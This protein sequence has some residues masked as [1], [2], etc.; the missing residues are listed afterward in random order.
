MNL[1]NVH[2]IAKRIQTQLFD[3]ANSYSS[4]MFKS[5]FKGSG[6]QFKEHQVYQYGDEIRFIDWSL[7]AKKN[8][9]Y[10]KTYEE[11]RNIHILIFVDLNPSMGLGSNGVTK[12]KAS[13]EICFLLILLA[14]KTKDYVDIV[15]LD[16]K[17]P[18]YCNN[19]TGESGVA[20]LLSVLYKY[21]VLHSDGKI[22]YEKL[23]KKGPFEIGPREIMKFLTRK[24]EVVFLSDYKN[25]IDKKLLLLLSKNYHAHFFCLRAPI[26]R[27]SVDNKV[28]SKFFMKVTELK[29]REKYFEKFEKGTKVKN[30]DVDSRYLE[31]FVEE[32]L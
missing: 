12:L 14:G 20:S 8:V 26:D 16:E 9:P 32:M 4:G 21:E 30:L 29:S 31:E 25:V 6:I 10:I 15:L 19:C 7:L 27:N 5:H 18:I 3:K 24:R 23:F 1:D 22:N 2:E 17:N 13:I 11:E 28:I